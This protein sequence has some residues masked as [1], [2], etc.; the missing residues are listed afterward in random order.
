MASLYGLCTRQTDTI[1]ICKSIYVDILCERIINILI[2]IANVTH[3]SS[4]FILK[5]ILLLK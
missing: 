4:I 2:G 5:S 3:V 1:V